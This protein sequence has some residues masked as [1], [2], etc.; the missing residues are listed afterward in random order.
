MSSVMFY[1][2]TLHQPWLEATDLAASHGHEQPSHPPSPLGVAHGEEMR[3]LVDDSIENFIE[4]G[5]QWSRLYVAV[6]L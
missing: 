2:K 6:A 1:A 3:Q 4:G 5:N